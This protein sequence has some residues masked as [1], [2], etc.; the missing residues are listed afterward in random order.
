MLHWE[1]IRG[2]EPYV[3]GSAA[4]LQERRWGLVQTYFGDRCAPWALAC[5]RGSI[6][7]SQATAAKP[8][9]GTT[10]SRPWDIWPDQLGGGQV[11]KLCPR[12]LTSPPPLR[13]PRRPLLWHQ[14][15]RRLLYCSMMRTFQKLL[16]GG[17]LRPEPP[18][19]SQ[20]RDKCEADDDFVPCCG[21][22][23]APPH[24][25]SSVGI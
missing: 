1:V 2:V 21:D 4:S 6:W 17:K 13:V 14:L 18:P 9:D 5:T 23:C 25:G 12:G 3:G 24:F 22:V 11:P 7:K 20:I 8:S 16:P 10:P 15:T 19:F